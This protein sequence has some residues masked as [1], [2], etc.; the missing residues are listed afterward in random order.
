M[1]HDDTDDVRAL[2]SKLLLSEVLAENQALVEHKQ[3][4]AALK[5]EQEAV[6]VQRQRAALEAA[7]AAERAKLAA[8]KDAALA[9]KAVQ[10]Q[11]LEQ[12]K[13][14]ILQ[15]RAA[16]KAEGALVRRKAGEE[17][18][19]LAAK[20]A[21]ARAAARAMTAA[22]QAS[23]DTLLAFRAAERERDKQLGEAVEAFCR[24]KAETDAQCAAAKAAAEATK[25]ARRKAMREVM[26]EN[27]CRWHTA[28]EQAVAADVAAAE[29]KAD[30]DAEAQR[31]R[32]GGGGGWLAGARAGRPRT[33]REEQLAAAHRSNQQQLA[34]KA[35]A[36]ADARAADAAFQVAWA[37]RLA[38]LRREEEAEV[39]DARA[40]ALKVQEF[41]QWQAA[42]AA[43][44]KQAAGVAHAQDALM[45]QTAVAEA[46]EKLARYGRLLADEAVARGLDRRPLAKHVARAR[47]GARR[48]H[49]QHVTRLARAGAAMGFSLAIDRHF[50]VTERGSTIGTEVKA[51][52]ATFLTMSYILLV[53]PKI[54]GV[55]GLPVKA[56][57]TATALSSTAASLLTG[58]FANMPVGLSPGMGLN[59]YLVFSQVLGLGVSVERALAGCF[60]AAG[61]IGVLALIRALD[62]ILSVVPDSI[63]LATV[64]G[65]GLLLTFIAL[66]TAKIVVPDQETMVTMGNLLG[67]EPLLA[68]GGLAVIAA[69][70]FRNVKGSIII[71]IVITALAYCAAK[72]TWP[73]SFIALPH[74]VFFKLDFTDLFGPDAT[75]SAWS[76]VLAYTLVMAFDIG[77]AMFG[78]CNL[79]GLVQGG[80]V[81]GSVFTYACAALGTAL[82]AVTGTTPLIIAAESAVGIKEGGRTGLVS[83]TIAGCFLL[84][85]FLAPL[86]QDIPQVATA[87]VLVLV[88]AMMMGESTHIDWS[89]MMTAV[90]AFLTIVIQPFTFSIANGIYAGLA[91]T[92]LLWILTGAFLQHVPWL[93]ARFG[94]G[95]GERDDLAA[96][97]WDALADGIESQ[98]SGPSAAWAAAGGGGAAAG[99]GGVGG[100]PIASSPGGARRRVAARGVPAAGSYQRG[101]FSMLINTFGSQTSPGALLGSAMHSEEP[102]H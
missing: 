100:I 58:I 83:V 31:R 37:Q 46:D 68:I 99:A 34:R 70:H 60:V 90:P 23:N 66:Q 17:A 8:A 73:T 75:A 24:Q 55:A 77:G 51:G 3:R 64:V 30:A 96:G 56:V 74:L 65:M 79:A 44:K 18:A 33:R 91:M 92:A 93:A 98:N 15:E 82:G 21:A 81:P 41:Q 89:S 6:F 2:H 40:R 10:M 11:Q 78:L 43:A 29:A 45:A 54:L 12:L 13:A 9:Q 38:E 4:V 72:H 94:P 35:A 87:P 19:Q 71:G 76:A 97:G 16:G 62:L 47:Q 7:E 52:I 61:I 49:A 25:E 85:I 28:T 39:A 67:L 20:E 53:N 101:S 80:R 57:V 36:K 14:R 48:A 69:L 84:S 102:E 63:K 5:A 59:A 32:R 42:R 26:E 88:G 50:K 1:L 22:T 86:L 95:A 27:Y